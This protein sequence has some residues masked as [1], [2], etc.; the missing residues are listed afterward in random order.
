MWIEED[1]KLDFDD[2]LIRPQTS[3]LNSRNEVNLTTNSMSDLFPWSIPIIASNMD[4]TGTFAM[5][6]S[7]DKLKLLTC[8]HK[9]YSAEEL[10]A[11]FKSRESLRCFYSLGTT[12]LDIDK[13]F[14]VGEQTSLPF[15]CIDLANAYI[16]LAIET[17]KKVR[18]RFPFST[19]MVGNVA[20][21]DCFSQLEDAGANIVKVGI[22]P[23]KICR[24]RPVTGVGYP[25]FSAIVECKES[26]IKRGLK[27]RICSDGGCKTSGD[28]CKAFGAGADMVMIGTMLAGTDECEGEW[29]YDTIFGFPDYKLAK[30][31]RVYGMSSK[32]AMKRHGESV[33]EYRASEGD[34]FWVDWKGPVE[35]VMKDILGGLRSCCTYSN[36][37]TLGELY[38]KA[39]FV[40]VNRTHQENNGAKN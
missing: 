2:V 11:F 15:I 3:Q 4:C 24:T 12:V 19:I 16:P 28:I 38:E 40:R 20:T 5:A 21:S 30:R 10:I 34:C 26:I 33:K 35:H 39:N 31:L 29:G 13:L 27:L 9:F 23:S 1:I 37:K 6:K 22:G 14:K 32:E 7:L 17:V 25:Q 18:Q 36:A 8:L